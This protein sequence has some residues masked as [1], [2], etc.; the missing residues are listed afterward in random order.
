MFLFLLRNTS[1]S[2][3]HFQHSF[4]RG[5]HARW[6]WMVATRQ[7][8]SKWSIR[9]KDCL[10]LF[11]YAL[12][13]LKAPSNITLDGVVWGNHAGSSCTNTNTL[14][15]KKSRAS[16]IDLNHLLWKGNELP[17]TNTIR[18]SWSPYMEFV[19]CC[20]IMCIDCAVVMLCVTLLPW[21]VST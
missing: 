8:K 9:V 21:C 19:L 1:F 20:P 15:N 16:K 17:P 12:L 3:P 14:C 5:W 6:H 7:P 13:L 2:T 10:A 11:P 18:T 4:L